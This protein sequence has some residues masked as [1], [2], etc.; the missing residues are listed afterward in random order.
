VVIYEIRVVPDG[1]RFKLRREKPLRPRDSLTHHGKI[2]TVQMV[3][4]DPDR[5][6]H[7]IAEVKLSIAPA[8]SSF[9]DG[10]QPQ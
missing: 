1:D 9:P 6:S 2:Y 7:A 3:I 5:K 4:P 10:E 8:E